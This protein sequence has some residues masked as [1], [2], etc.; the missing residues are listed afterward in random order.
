MLTVSPAELEQL[1]TLPVH[2]AAI[3]SLA[4]N[5]HPQ[6]RR[7]LLDVHKRKLEEFKQDSNTQWDNSY[8]NKRYSPYRYPESLYAT[9]EILKNVE[10]TKPGDG[11]NAPLKR[12][13]TANDKMSI[14]E[15]QLHLSNQAAFLRRNMTNEYEDLRMFQNSEIELLIKAKDARDPEFHKTVEEKRKEGL[16]PTARQ[17]PKPIRKET[18]SIT[19][20]LITPPIIRSPVVQ[21]TASPVQIQSPVNDIPD[22]N[23]LKNDVTLSPFLKILL[24]LQVVQQNWPAIATNWSQY[25]GIFKRKLMSEENFAKGILEDAVRTTNNTKFSVDQGKIDITRDSARMMPDTMAHVKLLIK[26]VMAMAE[27]GDIEFARVPTVSREDTFG[28]NILIDIMTVGTRILAETQMGSTSVGRATD[29]RQ[30][31]H[32]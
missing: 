5:S 19:S 22:L 29:P 3:R 13:L 2:D 20:A 30:R 7:Q 26:V 6:Q 18:S 24:N 12:D 32:K 25:Y 1:S 14:N 23:A 21:R 31:V 15:L 16:R 10:A 28:P 4:G 8:V 9:P 11:G 27:E 17:V